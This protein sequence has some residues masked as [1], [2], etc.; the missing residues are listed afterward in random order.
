MKKLLY[1]FLGYSF[2]AIWFSSCTV[3]NDLTTDERP[4]YDSVNQVPTGRPNEGGVYTGSEA[5]VTAVQGAMIQ[6]INKKEDKTN[7]LLEE[8]EKEKKASS[9]LRIQGSLFG[10]LANPDP[11]N[12]LTIVITEKASG[13]MEPHTL[14]PR[15]CKEMFLPPGDYQIEYIKNGKIINNGFISCYTVTMMKSGSYALQKG[16]KYEKLKFGSME[17]YEPITKAD[18]DITIP[19]RF[20]FIGS[21]R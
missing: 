19:A 12:N 20:Q 17:D 2:L 16:W 13:F 3:F 4:R 8:I 18:V 14:F 1:L 7:S 21:E 15:S 9:I 11:N 10:I 5:V 6:K